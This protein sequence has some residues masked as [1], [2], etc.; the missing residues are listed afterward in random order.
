MRP[1]DAV[2]RSWLPTDFWENPQTGR[3][4][5]VGKLDRRSL[6]G[7]EM[8]DPGKRL[9]DLALPEEKVWPLFL[10][11]LT[12]LR[13]GEGLRIRL[14]ID[15]VE[16][17]HLPWECMALPQTYRGVGDTDFLALR[18]DVSI[19]RSD[20][21]E[22]PPKR[23]PKRDAIRVVGIVSCPVDQAVL[24]VEAD[25]RNLNQ[26]IESLNQGA[27]F[28]QA[29]HLPEIRSGKSGLVFAGPVSSGHEWRPFSK[30][31]CGALGGKPFRGGWSDL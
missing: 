19:V 27:F 28:R 22:A 10:Q 5:L 1:D 30:A 31:G 29:E 16:L 25:K 2:V 8:F 24:D 7:E 21:V 9:A 13:E 6:T 4:G 20:T 18:R 23:P 15:A 26:A 12:A 14:R 17:A 11:S 3:G